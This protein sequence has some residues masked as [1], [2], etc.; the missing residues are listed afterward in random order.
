MADLKRIFSQVVDRQLHAAVLLLV[1]TLGAIYLS[2]LQTIPN[3]S[4][5]YYMIDVGETQI[6][7]N[8]WGTLH[9]TG[10][11]LYVMAGSSLTALFR[12]VGISA[13]AAPGLV[14]LLWGLLALLLLYGLSLHLTGRIWASAGA[15]FLFGLTRTVWAHH[16]IAEIYTFGLLILIALLALGLWRREDTF[17]TRYPARLY[18]MAL[19]GGIGVAH[20]RALA[21]AIPALVCAVWPK[22]V[23]ERRRLPGVLL[24]C[25][26]LG[27][28]GF[29]QYVYLP[30]RANA[31]ADW[32]YGDP[33]TWQGFLDQ[34]LGREARRFVGSPASLAA[35]ADNVQLING[36]LLRD[37]TLP[38]LLAGLCGLLLGLRTGK[39]RPAAVALLLNAAAAYGFHVALYTDVLSALILPVTLSAALGWLFLFDWI[40]TYGPSSARLTATGSMFAVAILAA[41]LLGKNHAFIREL[42]TDPTGLDTAALVGRAPPGST[43]MLAWG[44]RYF[45][46][47]FAHDVERRLRHVQLVDDKADF[48]ALLRRGGLLVT[49]EYTRF[50]QPVSWWEARIGQPVYVYAA[51]PELVQIAIQPQVSISAD[52]A[53]GDEGVRVE[54]LQVICAEAAL[55][56]LE[57]VWHTADRPQRDLSVFVHLL[58]TNDRII[59]QDD[60]FAPVYGWR[61]LTTWLPGERVRDIYT[62]P[63]LP[64]EARI[65]F[66]LYYQAET[67]AFVNVL[68]QTAET[69]G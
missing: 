44:P 4:S 10:Y 59:A 30:L 51:G 55:T 11:P 18:W 2:T 43:V 13:A 8:T 67:G 21:M 5:H 52:P 58:D 36:V 57:I 40:L 69:C 34:F 29:L 65:R 56:T 7:L 1:A 39:H 68:E 61:P 28:L 20:H 12:E 24:I 50:N 62:L 17:L 63:R 14:S 32:V 6:V 49:P 19:L 42:T 54:T 25:G 41:V 26:L 9:A 47:A 23:A 31:N 60:R 38:G 15:V 37:L 16:T 46:A 64:G 33:G 53:A 3:G 48:A 66:G 22:L 45:A 27:A 35:L